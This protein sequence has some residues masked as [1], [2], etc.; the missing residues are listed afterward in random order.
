MQRVTRSERTAWRLRVLSAR[1]PTLAHSHSG[2][3]TARSVSVLTYLTYLTC[4][5]CLTCLTTT[6][7]M[8]L[9]FAACPKSWRLRIM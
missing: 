3:E 5:T 6:D 8:A 7:G 9:V 1:T 4:L 2:I